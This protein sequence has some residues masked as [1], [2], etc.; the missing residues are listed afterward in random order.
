MSQGYVWKLSSGVHVHPGCREAF[1]RHKRPVY[2]SI[3]GAVYAGHPK[4]T[5]DARCVY[6]NKALF[7]KGKGKGAS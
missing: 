6:C 2:P 1:Q 5:P 4:L 7:N 3:T